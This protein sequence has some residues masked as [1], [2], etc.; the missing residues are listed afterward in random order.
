MTRDQDILNQ[1]AE[2]TTL[3]GV[4]R[5]IKSKS[6]VSKL[7]WS[8]IVVA[9]M[10]VFGYYGYHILKTY[11]LFDK[12]VGLEIDATSKA[13]LFPQLT[14]CN[15]QGMSYI[16]MV[17]IIDKLRP[18]WSK[19]R[20]LPIITS[21]AIMNNTGPAMQHYFNVTIPAYDYLLQRLSYR[22]ELIYNIGTRNAMALASGFNDIVV[23]CI[24][25]DTKCDLKGE[26]IFD[27]YFYKCFRITI[28]RDGKP[29]Q[30]QRGGPGR[31]VYLTLFSGPMPRPSD[32]PDIEETSKLFQFISNFP[33]VVYQE[34]PASSTSGFRLVVHSHNNTPFPQKDGVTIPTHSLTNVAVKAA[35]TDRVGEPYGMCVAKTG[36]YHSGDLYSLD[37]CQTTCLQKATQKNCKCTD[38]SLP[39]DA[40]YNIT[41]DDICFNFEKLVEKYCQQAVK[42][43][44]FSPAT[45]CSEEDTKKMRESMIAASKCLTMAADLPSDYFQE[46]CG[47]HPPCEKIEYET[48]EERSFLSPQSSE[49]IQQLFLLKLKKEPVLK[50]LLKGRL[51]KGKSIDKLQDV[52]PLLME[53]TSFVN[54]YMADTNTLVV[55]ESAGYT[56]AEMVADL[57]GML[58]L[59]IG[60][61]V[62]TVAEILQMIIQYCFSCIGKGPKINTT[63]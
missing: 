15:M 44:M 10:C 30:I 29:L 31:G 45:K 58:G 1:F 38:I 55:K 36:L 62:I 59:C 46:E 61:S 22:N 43:E 47:C 40:D 16:N 21:D 19:T 11:M 33:G 37:L 63:S 26:E 7:T 3:H 28:L 39:W 12:K 13:M 27:S 23:R 17:Y 42:D 6:V 25:M 48:K 5:I 18:Y 54:V 52:V 50:R 4:P 49:A 8:F 57:G 9:S 56:E 24:Y 32:F 14:L 41:D 60:V 51:A 35:R 53:S 2:D 20:Y 34:N